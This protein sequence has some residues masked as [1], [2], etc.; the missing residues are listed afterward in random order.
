[1]NR[2]IAWS[3]E[4]CDRHTPNDGISHGEQGRPREDAHDQGG[5][6]TE[7]NYSDALLAKRRDPSRGEQQPESVSHAEGEKPG[8]QEQRRQ[9]GDRGCA[10]ERAEP[11]HDSE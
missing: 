9:V 3:R 11:C 8:Q 4:R 6:G 5:A 2:G 10:N 7:Q 1:M